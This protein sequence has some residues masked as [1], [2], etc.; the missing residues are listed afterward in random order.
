MK[1]LN[2][3]HFHY[4][5]WNYGQYVKGYNPYFVRLSHILYAVKK[6]TTYLV[7]AI[8][9]ILY[10]YNYQCKAEYKLFYL[11]VYPVFQSAKIVTLAYNW[12]ISKI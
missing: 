6:Y 4:K 10:H 3:C 12:R 9:Y 2:S 11:P 1:N 5:F 7:F 8:Y